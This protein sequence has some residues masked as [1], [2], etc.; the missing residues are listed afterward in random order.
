MSTEIKSDKN[1]YGPNKSPFSGIGKSFRSKIDSV[2]EYE[3]LEEDEGAKDDYFY[4]MPFGLNYNEY[5]NAQKLKSSLITKYRD[6]ELSEAIKGN[7]AS[8]DFGSV[9]TINEELKL[10]LKKFSREKAKEKMLS[11]LRLLYGI[12]DTKKKY[13]NSRGYQTIEDLIYHPAFSNDAKSLVDLINSMDSKRMMERISH[14]L[15]KS[16]ELVYCCSGFHEKEDFLFFDIETLGLFNRPIILIG[17]AKFNGDALSINQYFLK[18]LNQEPEALNQF[19]SQIGPKTVLVSYNGKSF[20]V[21]YI[22]ERLS[23]YGMPHIKE[24]THFDMLHFSRRAWRSRYPNCRL[25]TLEKYLFGVERHDDVPSALVPEF[26]ETYLRTGNIGPVIP[27]IEHNRQ[28]L[29]T[30]T[31]IFSKLYEEWSQ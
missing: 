29:I 31:N 28:D 27:I 9:F 11:E 10:G 24:M 22:R 1:P 7:E 8:G 3:I 5:F 14:W 4:G 16:D 30:L 18:D 13:L 6:M 2:K 19:L 17:A 20:D 15:S 21:P 23:Y 12:G 25:V 26:Y